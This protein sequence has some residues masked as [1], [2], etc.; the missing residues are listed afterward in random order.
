[1]ADIHVLDLTEVTP[2]SNDN[3]ILFDRDTGS[4]TSTRFDT[5]KGAVTGDVNTTIQTLTKELERNIIVIGNSYVGNPGRECTAVLEELF[6]HAY[7]FYSGG[8]GFVTYTGHATTFSDL[9]DNAIAST[10]FD[11]DDITDILFVSAIGDTNA[12]N[13][14]SLGTYGANLITALDAIN[15]KIASNFPNV[16]RVMVTLGESRNT[17]N[18]L[19]HNKYENVFKLHKLFITYLAQKNIDYIGWAGFNALFISSL[20]ESDNYHPSAEGA[21]VIGQYIRDGFLGN[22]EYVTKGGFKSLTADYTSGSHL[23]VIGRFTPDHVSL[24]LRILTATAGAPITLVQD[25]E[26]INT[27]GMDMPLPPP[28]TALSVPAHIIEFSSGT[29]KDYNVFNIVSDSDGVMAITAALS[30]TVATSGFDNA[31]LGEL[32]IIEY[33]L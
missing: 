22:L 33:D 17:T 24:N 27:S 26:I 13:E 4:A 8:V 30:P 5:L 28:D 10:S 23:G 32:S 21:K 20:F 29:D 25:A 11:N 18:I 14:T 19:T 9:L 31:Y 1:M 16:K 12:I 3:V 15:I 2:S 7:R 6:D